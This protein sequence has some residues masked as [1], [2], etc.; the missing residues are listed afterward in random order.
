M[1][2]ALYK[3]LGKQVRYD[4]YSHVPSNQDPLQMQLSLRMFHQNP[5]F[6]AC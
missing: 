1:C 2:Q 4:P 3:A 5:K 6:K